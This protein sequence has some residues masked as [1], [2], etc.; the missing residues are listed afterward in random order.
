M[1]TTNRALK[2]CLLVAVS[3]LGGA[4]AP[5]RP[6]APA[7]RE[8]PPV[9]RR[10]VLV[11][12]DGM[13]G[14]RLARLLS[15]PGKLGTKGLRRLADSGFFAVRSVPCTPS[16]TPAAHATH[17]TGAL[18][19]DTGIVGNVLLDPGKPFGARR[20]GF[21]TRLRAETLCEAARRQGKRVGVMAYP[22][23]EGTPPT[24][25]AGF[26]MRWVSVSMARPRVTRLES[27][28][29]LPASAPGALTFS[30][31]RSA[32]LAFPPT[33]HRA[34]ITAVDSTDDARTNYDEIRVEPE[35]GPPALVHVGES[36]PVEVRG[37][38]GRAGSWCK[39]LSLAADLS[40]TEIYCGG[41]WESDA[42]PDDF[43]HELDERAGFWPGRADTNVF[44]AKSQHPEI[45]MEQSDR[46]TEFL[47]KADLA[48]LAR[49]DW[50]LLLLYQSEVDAVEHEF[51]LSEPR[52]ESYT[53][54]RAARFAAY[55]DHAFADA[56]RAI[57]R[58]LAVLTPADALLVTADHGM[59]PLHTELFPSQ[60][61]VENGFTKVRGESGIDPSS[62]AAALASS[63]VAHVYVNPAAPAGTLDRVEAVIAAFRAGGE[64]PWDRVVRREAAGDLA[65]DAPESGDLI[66]LAKPGY[67]FSM[68]MKPGRVSGPSEEYGG[69][70]YRAA[71]PE[72]DATFLAAG[73]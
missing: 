41:I 20:N 65:L 53:A 17:I 7:A 62:A 51:L 5:A 73:P 24:G 22:H 42:F 6:A 47:T 59:T 36:F 21:D 23:G 16:L 8:P 72:L 68:A 27:G 61:L 2:T 60:L 44:G 37:K 29:W 40:D 54:E 39:L 33:A 34:V 49:P 46:L 64:S 4:C 32:S 14:V 71:Y 38:K 52:Q 45:Y 19:R 70:G 48:A 66:I 43:R 35:V 1:P 56:D 30:P 67:H 15:E 25:C 18:P 9:A 63:G 3:A 13:S 31:A 57:E 28:S 69:H 50:D 11:S 12:M 10:A 55:I 26:G 58:F